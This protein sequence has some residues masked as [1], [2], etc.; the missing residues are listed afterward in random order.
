MS[1]AGDVATVRVAVVGAH[2]SGQ[3]LN[4]QL[5]ARGA[6]ARGD[7]HHDGPVLPAGGAGDRAAR[8]RG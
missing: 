6:T 5:T 7:H 1:E 4:H 3:P 8:S 2:L